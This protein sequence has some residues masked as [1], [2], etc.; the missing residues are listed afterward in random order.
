[1]SD[2][3]IVSSAIHSW[4]NGPK[5]IFIDPVLYTTEISS[6]LLAERGK[7]FKEYHVIP[8]YG[9]LMEW[10]KHFVQPIACIVVISNKDYA[11]DMKK[12]RPD[13]EVRKIEIK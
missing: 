8:S 10:V 6:L 5:Y 1:M 11:E 2:L 13:L 3:I 12:I 7:H 9:R 4:S